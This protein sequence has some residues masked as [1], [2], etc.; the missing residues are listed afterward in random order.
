MDFSDDN[1]RASDRAGIDIDQMIVAEDD[2]KQRAFLIVLNSI[3]LSLV[4]NTKTVREISDKLEQH[5]DNFQAHAENEE[6]LM[7]QGRGA[8]R[9]M[10]WV[11]G[12]AQAATIGVGSMIVTEITSINK[13]FHIHE[14][15]A[16]QIES[17]VDEIERRLK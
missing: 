5:L 11:L 8:W 9:V 16:Q 10:A 17:R 7:N 6:A 14:I 15:K 1:R 4:A 3:N 2:P 12:I 13:S